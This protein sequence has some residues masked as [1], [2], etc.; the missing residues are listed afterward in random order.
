MNRRGTGAGSGII[1]SL[2]PFALACLIACCFMA[3]P[4]QAAGR[5]ECSTIPSKILHRPVAYCALLPPSYDADKTHRYPV[6]YF[7]HGLGENEQILLNS[8]GWDLIQDM[9]DQKKIGEFLI[10]APAAGRSFFVNSRDGKVRYE[11]FFVREFLPFIESRYRVRP[12]RHNRGI[13]G[14]SMGGYGA[15]RFALLYPNLFGSVSAHSPA[16]IKDLPRAEITDQQQELLSR[17]VGMAFGMPFD[18]A[19]WNRE[20]PF[21]IVKSHPRPAGLQIYFDCGTED[22]FG[23]DRGAQ[24]FHDLLVSLKI[25]HEFHLYPGGHDWAYFAQ[26]FPASLEFQSRAFG[27]R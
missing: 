14:V 4:T 9:W 6:L 26:H 13:S 16:L 18:R 24:A 1:A 20:S 17:I 12:G 3:I 15:L 8:G 7:L 27:Y 22:D 23:F 2:A 25:P 21:T 10:V 5:A 19:Y 11:D